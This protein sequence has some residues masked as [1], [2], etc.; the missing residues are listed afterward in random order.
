MLALRQALREVRRRR[1]R[2]AL[3]RGLIPA[4]GSAWVVVGN[5][6]GRR[7]DARLGDRITVRGQRFNVVGILGPTLTGPDSFVF[8]SFPTAQRLLIDSEP[9]LRRLLLVPGSSLLPIATAA[10]VFWASDQDPEAVA[11]RIRERLPGLSVVSPRDATVQLDR[12]VA[13]LNALIVSSGLV[14]LLVASLA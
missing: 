11:A 5:R 4:P 10:A 3:T 9:L 13:F 8:M 12:A 1:V 7:W 6:V 2:S 14:A